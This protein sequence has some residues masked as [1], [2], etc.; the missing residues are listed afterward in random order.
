M[1]LARLGFPLLKPVLSR[2][3]A[4]AAH[5]LTIRLLNWAP[6]A[7]ART[8]P[9]LAVDCFGLK[10]PNPLGLAAGFDKNADVPD[11]LLNLGF[12]FV[13]VG[14]VTPRPQAGNDRPRLFRLAEDQAVINRMGFNNL[15][16]SIVRRHLEARRE[17]GGIVG[18]NIGANRNSADWIADYMQAVRTFADVASYL[19]INISSPNTPGLRGLQSREA[20]AELLAAL[21]GARSSKM[22]P[23][24]IKIAPDLGEGELEDIA[25]IASGGLVDGVIVSN[26]TISRP[27]LRSAEHR[28]R[29][30]LSGKPLFE[31]STRMLARLYLLT[32]GRLKL[33]GVGGISDGESALAKIEAGASLIQ[34]YTAL[35]YRGPALIDEILDAL[36]QKLAASGLSSIVDVTGRRAKEIAHQGLSGT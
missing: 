2:M 23:L 5:R 7:G 28:Q 1:N 31:L 8:E 4:E 29:G 24:L 12:G 25:E 34:L 36:R 30:G 14:T 22:T 16:A 11:A 17:K 35:V 33:I 3:D 18:V 19:V 20:L 13:E 6:P 9:G 27:P 26:T 21:D 32:G 15:G 10:F